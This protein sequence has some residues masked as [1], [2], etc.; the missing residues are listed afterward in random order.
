[1]LEEETKSS[2]GQGNTVVE[3]QYAV[4][5]TALTV[6]AGQSQAAGHWNAVSL[7]M[8]RNYE[9]SLRGQQG[10]RHA[11]LEEAGPSEK[12]HLSCPG[13]KPKVNSLLSPVQ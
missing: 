4:P 10:L 3:H 5:S 7:I 1:M 6:T 2:G 13:T 11:C 9:D 8:T 12:L